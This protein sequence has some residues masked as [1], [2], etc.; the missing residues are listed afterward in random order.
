MHKVRAVVLRSDNAVDTERDRYESAIG[1]L[2]V[3][4]GNGHDRSIDA[5]IS[6]QRHFGV[7]GDVTVFS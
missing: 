6:R 5:V 7:H 1:A 4:S 2:L 3:R